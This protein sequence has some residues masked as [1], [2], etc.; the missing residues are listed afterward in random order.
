MEESVSATVEDVRQNLTAIQDAR[1]N[2]RDI[3][4]AAMAG[5]PTVIT[6]YGKAAAAVV[7]MSWFFA[8]GGQLPDDVRR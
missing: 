3:V 2:L 7:P 8:H 5:Q 6:R 4:D 1:Q